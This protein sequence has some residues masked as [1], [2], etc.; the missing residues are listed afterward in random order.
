MHLI[1]A[2]VVISG[3]IAKLKTRKLQRQSIFPVNPTPELTVLVQSIQDNISQS[4]GGS[5][6]DQNKIKTATVIN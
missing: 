5:T 3:L 4:S 2:P 6:V 1:M